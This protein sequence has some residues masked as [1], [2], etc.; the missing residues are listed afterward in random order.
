MQLENQ[1]IDDAFLVGLYNM[2]QD[3][4]IKTATQAREVIRQ[5]AVFALP[6]P[7]GR[8]ESEDLG[9]LVAREIRWPRRGPRTAGS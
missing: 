9:P 4:N 2:L 8:R 7:V 3:E 6:P 5:K 1:E